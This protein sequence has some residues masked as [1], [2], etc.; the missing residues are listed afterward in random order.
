[1]RLQCGWILLVMIVG[2]L[3][4]PATAG[5]EVVRRTEWAAVDLSG[6]LPAD[7][8]RPEGKTRW[9]LEGLTL[10]ESWTRTIK[11]KDGSVTSLEQAD[12]TVAAPTASSSILIYTDP[13]AGNAVE[14]WLLPDRD[15]RLLEVDPLVPIR[16]A[17]QGGRGTDELEIRTRRL[18][19]G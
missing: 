7:L 4:V 5:A 12:A 14:R 6:E 13:T 9:D 11:M 1:M 19:L 2:L 18:G 3:S 17:E 16:I 8:L 15:P 10:E